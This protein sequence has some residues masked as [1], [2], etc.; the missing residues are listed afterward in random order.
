MVGAFA[1]LRPRHGG[2]I[3]LGTRPCRAQGRGVKE[4]EG[5]F[6]GQSFIIAQRSAVSQLFGLSTVAVGAVEGGDIEGPPTTVFS[7]VLVEL[8]GRAFILTAGHC[9][10]DACERLIVDTGRQRQWTN[11]RPYVARSNH[12]YDGDGGVDHGYIELA[13]ADKNTMEAIAKVFLNASQVDVVLASE[14]HDEGDWMCLSGY[15]FDFYEGNDKGASIRMMHVPGL[16]AGR[17]NSPVSRLP[18]S[19]ESVN[20]L[21]IAVPA[22]QH[23]GNTDDDPPTSVRLPPLHGASGG[24]LWRMRTLSPEGW[25]AR[26][27]S[28][29]GTLSMASTSTAGDTV[30]WFYRRS[31][32]SHH[33]RLI[34]DDYE[35]LRDRLHQQWGLLAFM[36]AS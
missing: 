27:V 25:S 23:V 28:L 36:D 19:S 31:L 32:L 9:V 22:G 11:F 24:G 21:D 15:P 26:R 12:R 10:E 29:V 16:P 6:E 5:G 4:D 17:H 20:K 35:D 14:L 1:G 30:N 7:G 8:F 2:E 18:P 3:G 34:A 33:I 13:P